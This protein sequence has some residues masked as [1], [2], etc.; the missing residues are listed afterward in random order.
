MK[1]S[2]AIQKKANQ[3]RSKAETK[4]QLKQRAKSIVQTLKELY[5]GAKCSLDY[6]NPF[7]LL[8]ATILSAQCTDKRVNMVTPALFKQF[9]TAEKMS[10]ADQGQIENLVR[11]TGFYKNKAKNILLCSQSIVNHY[12]GVVPNSME[13]LSSLAGVGRKTANVVLGNAFGVP[14]MVVDTHVTRISNLLGLA[15]GQDA[16]KIEKQLEQVIERSDWIIFSHLLI[17]HGRQ[18]C[19]ARRPKCD[20]C[21]LLKLCLRRGL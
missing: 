17:E 20:G 15:K 8:I 3:G 10:Q 6:K 2:V 11:S 9:P 5:P 21:Q 19:V 16:V 13:Q 12:A 1:P 18:I 7:E 14:G 4:D